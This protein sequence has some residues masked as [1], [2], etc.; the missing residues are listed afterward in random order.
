MFVLQLFCRTLDG[1]WMHRGCVQPSPRIPRHTTLGT[2][3]PPAPR[4]RS[5]RG[6]AGRAGPDRGAVAVE[7]APGV[8]GRGRGP[9]GSPVEGKEWLTDSLQRPPTQP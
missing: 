5:E 4:P 3:R 2:R 6:K 8:P 1:F 9:G 7:L